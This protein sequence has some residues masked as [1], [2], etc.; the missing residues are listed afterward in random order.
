VGRGGEE[1]RRGDKFTVHT[2]GDIT[3]YWY[4]IHYISITLHGNG[5]WSETM[6]PG[7]AQ[8]M[9]GNRSVRPPRFGGWTSQVVVSGEW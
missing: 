8:Y 4:Y 7:T 6:C 2:Q 9:S 1:G 3:L 5:R